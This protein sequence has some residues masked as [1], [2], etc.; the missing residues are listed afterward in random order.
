MPWIVII[1]YRLLVPLTILRWPLW[2]SLLAVV[3]DNVD[4]IVADAMGVT[5]FALYNPID[6]IMDT[7]MYLLMGVVAWR[8]KNQFARRLVLGLLAYRMIGV[9]LYEVLVFVQPTADFRWLLFVFPN[10]F[11]FVFLYVVSFQTFLKRDPFRTWR[12]AMPALVILLIVKLAQEYMLH[13]AQ[14]PI[15]DL[16]KTTI[17]R[18]LGIP[19]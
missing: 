14:F 12:Q 9:L 3:A 16:I 5:D 19:L 13:V 2:G 10:L 4:V 8:W 11:V 7:Y 18:P 17:F 1:F 15:Y 6:K